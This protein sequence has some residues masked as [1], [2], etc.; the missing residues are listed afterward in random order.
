MFN[1]Q[2]YQ[3]S[4]TTAKV[5]DAYKLRHFLAENGYNFTLAQAKN[6]SRKLKYSHLFSSQELLNWIDG[7]PNFV[8][9]FKKSAAEVWF[10]QTFKTHE[11]PNKFQS[12]QIVKNFSRRACGHEH[13]CW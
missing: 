5:K 13:A 4:C 3:F 2:N 12:E 10:E 1:S 8:P 7:K 11:R 6:L 9:V